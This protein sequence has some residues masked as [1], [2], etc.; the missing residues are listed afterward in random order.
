LLRLL[1]E[2]LPGAAILLT[3][4]LAVVSQIVLDSQVFGSEHNWFHR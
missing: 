1:S 4:A 3:M 2:K